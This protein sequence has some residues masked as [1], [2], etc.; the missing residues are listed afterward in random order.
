MSRT[1]WLRPGVNKMPRNS[2]LMT[3]IPRDK[4]VARCKERALDYLDRAD[5]KNAVASIIADMDARID[6]KLPHHLT[7]VVVSLLMADDAIGVR[8]LIEDLR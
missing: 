1:D 5:L 6:C 4:Y 2:S 3:D 7:A 8:G